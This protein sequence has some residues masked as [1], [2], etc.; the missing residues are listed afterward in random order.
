MD[1]SNEDLSCT[2]NVTELEGKQGLGEDYRKRKD[3]S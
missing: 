1:P 2:A 3:G